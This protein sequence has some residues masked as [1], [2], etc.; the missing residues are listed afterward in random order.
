MQDS[1]T[2][3]QTV[4]YLAKRWTLLI[5]L[6]LY[7]GEGYTRRFSELREA[8]PGITPKVLSERLKELEEEELISRKVDATAFPVR[9]DYTLT[10]SGLEI[11]GIIRAI[12]Q[13]AL[14]WKIENLA[15]GNQDCKVCVI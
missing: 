14:K 9:T 5:I 8:L 2:V 7:K 15:C 1:C 3:N 12:K 11:I 4:R 10:E 6:E 13:W